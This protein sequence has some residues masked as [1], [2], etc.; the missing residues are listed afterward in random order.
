MSAN[1]KA[2]EVSNDFLIFSGENSITRQ[3]TPDSTESMK[4]MNCRKANTV[5]TNNTDFLRSLKIPPYCR[6]RAPQ[7]YLVSYCML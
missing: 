5:L 4:D 3:V 7:N 2:T 6:L 1:Y